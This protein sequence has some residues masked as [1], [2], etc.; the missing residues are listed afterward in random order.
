ML[1]HFTINK[2]KFL[3]DNYILS[4]VIW[5]YFTFLICGLSNG[6]TLSFR[7]LTNGQIPISW[8]ILQRNRFSAV[9]PKKS[10][11]TTKKQTI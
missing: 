1:W 9:L 5:Q 6:L 2:N 7:L 8:E 3:I 11:T 10:L 4:Y